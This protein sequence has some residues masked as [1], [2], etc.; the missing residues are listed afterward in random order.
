[1]VSSSEEWLTGKRYLDISE[2]AERCY[3][4]RAEEGMIL[5]DR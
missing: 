3:K 5:M 2:L 4:E 1:V